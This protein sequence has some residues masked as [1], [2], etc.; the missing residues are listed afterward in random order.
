MKTTAIDPHKSSIGG[1]DANIAALIPYAALFVLSW[2]NYANW[3]VW[4]VPLVFLFLEKESVFVKFSAA[5]ALVLGIVRSAFSIV[6]S[7]L[8][9]IF[10]ALAANRIERYWTSE[11]IF[12]GSTRGAGG[13]IWTVLLT[14]TGI[15]S[16]IVA[17]AIAIAAAY[18]A[19]MAFSNKKLELPVA[20]G[21]AAKFSEKIG[22]GGDSN[23][24][25]SNT[26]AAP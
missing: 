1:L 3:I 18:A 5:Q 13:G 4:A 19:Y 20:S 2:F 9:W 22:G 16:W 25:S 10:S 12:S 15:I 8:G 6:F 23:S 7:I 26:N 24:G 17:A 14:I 21:L 11:A